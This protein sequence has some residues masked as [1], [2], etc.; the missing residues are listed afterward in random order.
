MD[1]IQKQSILAPIS[2]RCRHHIQKEN[3]LVHLPS[4]LQNCSVNFVTGTGIKEDTG[5]TLVAR[6]F[7]GD[8]N[9]CTTDD[10]IPDIKICQV[11]LLAGR[12]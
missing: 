1:H 6:T 11:G 4:W 8:T 2:V 9:Q 7:G 10:G 12:Q 3:A 5:Q